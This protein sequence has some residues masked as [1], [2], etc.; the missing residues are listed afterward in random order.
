MGATQGLGTERHGREP[1][2]ARTSELGRRPGGQTPWG[3][4]LRL[5]HGGRA[6]GE[7]ERL[8]EGGRATTREEAEG[9][10]R[11]GARGSHRME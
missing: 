1:R 11:G 7:R 9:A 2:G 10:E 4:E 5:G 6:A 3:R 8:G